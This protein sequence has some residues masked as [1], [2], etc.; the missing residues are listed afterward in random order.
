MY[1]NPY[2]IIAENRRNLTVFSTLEPNLGFE[3]EL[4]QSKIF[5]VNNHIEFVNFVEFTTGSIREKDTIL[6]RH[7]T[8]MF[9]TS[10][11]D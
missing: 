7:N 5:I 9:L 1:T 11:D 3:L 8:C 10:G 2:V 4:P 6:Y